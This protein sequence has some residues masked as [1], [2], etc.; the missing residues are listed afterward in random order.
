MVVSVENT[1]EGLSSR[2]PFLQPLNTQCYC[3]L[4]QEIDGDGSVERGV[5]DRSRQARHRRCR[6]FQGTSLSTFVRPMPAAGK[7][8]SILPSRSKIR[9]GRRRIC[10][11]QTTIFRSLAATR[12]GQDTERKWYWVPKSTHRAGFRWKLVVQTGQQRYESR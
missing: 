5:F 11:T 12:R 9:D 6:Q 3:S 2:E 1:E 8:I 7:H 10:L 4:N